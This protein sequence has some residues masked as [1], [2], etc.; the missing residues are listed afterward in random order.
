[1]AKN[2]C[3]AKAT[4]GSWPLKQGSTGDISQPKEDLDQKNTT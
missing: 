1:M 4:H 2:V 3:Y